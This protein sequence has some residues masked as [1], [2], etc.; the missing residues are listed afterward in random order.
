M[1]PLRSFQNAKLGVKLALGFVIMLSI[2]LALVA[3]DQR[4]MSSSEESFADFDRIATNSLLIANVEKGLLGTAVSAR[5]YLLYPTPANMEKLD[6][7][8]QIFA[9]CAKNRTKRDQEPGKN[10]HLD[11]NG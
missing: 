5:D 3:N 2:S 1:N 8:R 11:G 10:S 7:S 9:R 4:S 6:S